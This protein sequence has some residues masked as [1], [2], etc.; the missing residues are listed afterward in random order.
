MLLLRQAQHFILLKKLLLPSMSKIESPL[1]QR[2]SLNLITLTILATTLHLGR[3]ILTPLFFS[4]LLAMLLHPIVNFLT[5]NRMDRVASILISIIIS[6]LL[7]GTVLYFL[8]TQIGNFLDD[9]PALKSRLREVG[10][11]VKQWVQENFNIA[12]RKQTQYLNETAE[13]MSDNGPTMVQ[14]T[15]VTLTEIVSYVIFLPVYTFLILYHKDTIKKFLSEMFRRSEEDK[16]IEVLD[17]SQFICQQ[18]LTGMLI[19]LAIVFTLNTTGFLII[20]I[21]YPVFLAMIAALLNIVPYIGMLIANIFCILVTL[22]SA[23]DTSSIFW[24]AG[25]L[26]AVQIVDNNI[27]MPFIV[28]S[29]I[30]I[31]AMAIIIGVLIGGALCGIP[32]MFLALPGLAVMK[33]IF[34]RVDSL[35]PW[36]ILLGDEATTKREYKNPLK[37]IFSRSAKKVKSKEA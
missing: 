14:Q 11:E 5:R 9:I 35:K 31:N 15:V 12:I 17:E 27:L 4:I 32:G 16:V 7:I 37:S 18:Y 33:V 23:N 25:V 20:G 26:A 24:V 29:K 30:K 1:Y 10:T 36:A 6:L 8:S 21:K 28:G 34:E 3:G 2:I 13:K 22:V 19:E